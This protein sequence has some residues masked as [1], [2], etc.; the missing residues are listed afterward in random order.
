VLRALG[1]ATIEAR[2]KEFL[3]DVEFTGDKPVEEALLERG[4]A[5][6]LEATGLVQDSPQDYTVS[7]PSGYERLVEHINVHR[8]FRSI[9][10]GHQISWPDAVAS[11]KETVYRPMIEVIRSTEILQE[12]PGQT[13]TD[14]YL[15]T[16][17]HLH[18]LRQRYSPDVAPQRA[19]DEVKEK[20]RKK[21]IRAKRSRS[22]WSRLREL[23]GRSP[24]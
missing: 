11:W 13:E 20:E 3:T 5:D 8:Y 19:V 4:L 9:E 7:D 16:M 2:V 12:Y 6:F 10:A 14:L 1:A 18:H 21:R 24:G 22:F 15:F 17:D 23:F